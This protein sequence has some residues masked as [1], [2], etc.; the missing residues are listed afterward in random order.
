ML[1]IGDE[2]AHF[3]AD[4]LESSCGL[5]EKMPANLPEGRS[6]PAFS[7]AVRV[8]R[9]QIPVSLLE[10]H[11]AHNGPLCTVYCR[12]VVNSMREKFAATSGSAEIVVEGTA[13][14][15]STD[16]LS[17][18]SS[19]LVLSIMQILAEMKGEWGVG[20]YFGGGW[21]VHA[22]PIKSGGLQYSQTSKVVMSVDIRKY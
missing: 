4:A 3:L 6:D 10:R 19:A 9:G 13:S 8:L 18:L 17:E 15:E 22:E 11:T 5:S 20:G 16:R 12:R 14:S 21:E 2:L 7:R 1:H